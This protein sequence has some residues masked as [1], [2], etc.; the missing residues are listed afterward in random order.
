MSKFK[1]NAVLCPDFI[2]MRYLTSS[3]YMRIQSHE[4]I[5]IFFIII[6]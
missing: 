4:K 1:R 2:E 5:Y 6:I 3:K